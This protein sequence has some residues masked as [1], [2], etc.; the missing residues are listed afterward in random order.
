LSN[1]KRANTIVVAA[2][3]YG[4]L[5][6]FFV[7][8]VV[9]YIFVS[10]HAIGI[11]KLVASVMV[12]LYLTGP[13]ALILNSMP[14][15]ANARVSLRRINELFE[16]LD[17]ERV[18]MATSPIAE[19]NAISLLGV[20]YLHHVDD[21]KFGL[22]PIDLTIKKGL[23]TFIV[24]GNGSG[25]STLGK[26]V[27]LHYTPNEGS[28]YFGDTLIDATSMDAA[29]QNI[30][31]IF[32][33]YYLFDRLLIDVTSEQEGYIKGYLKR[34]QLDQ[35]VSII[36]GR[37]STTMLSDG[38]RKRLALLVAFLEDRDL[39]IFDEWAADQD[40]DFKR[41][42]YEEILPELRLRNKAIVV[43]THDD[44]YFH[45]ADRVFVMEDGRLIRSGELKYDPLIG[46][47]KLSARPDN[48]LSSDFIFG[49]D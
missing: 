42:F 19:W 5:L 13:V 1:G 22:G 11:D 24:G 43:I 37:F 21:S 34:F 9:A 18:A 32:T 2:A 35:K 47:N 7:I 31:S 4:D 29:R 8:G 23:I 16:K 39:Y 28:I 26:I 36:N 20:C 25:K 40:P 44:R 49:V 15:I 48:D 41:I 14:Q 33:D 38:Q 17:K 12:L 27:S 6:S 3:N 30:S 10:Y 45:V 46:E